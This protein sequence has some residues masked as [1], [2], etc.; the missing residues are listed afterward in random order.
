MQ[1]ALNEIKALITKPPVLA[2]PKTC[3]TLLLYIA[4]TT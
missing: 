4:T 1:K 2:S 3:E